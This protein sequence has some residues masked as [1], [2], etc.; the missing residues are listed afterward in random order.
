MREA[1]HGRAK[2]LH[3]VA[4]IPTSLIEKLIGEGR[5]THE[6]YQDKSQQVKLLEIIRSEYPVFLSTDKY[7]PLKGK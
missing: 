1:Q 7:I 5:L 4:S 3:R 6:Y 2:D